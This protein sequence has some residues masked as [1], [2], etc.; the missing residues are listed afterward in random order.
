MYSPVVRVKY[1][2]FRYVRALGDILW[3]C[4]SLFLYYIITLINVCI[5]LLLKIMFMFVSNPMYEYNKLFSL[6]NYYYYYFQFNLFIIINNWQNLC[7]S[8]A[9]GIRLSTLFVWCHVITLGLQV[10]S[11][12][13]NGHF[14][15]DFYYDKIVQNLLYVTPLFYW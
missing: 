11:R 6:P 15:V 8:S 3:G 7:R 2:S 4:W 9:L 10:L 12:H 13:N 14:F 5:T 1:T